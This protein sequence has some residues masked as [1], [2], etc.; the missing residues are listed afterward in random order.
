MSFPPP[1]RSEISRNERNFKFLSFLRPRGHCDRQEQNQYGLGTLSLCYDYAV[2]SFLAFLS[3][4][5]E[6][7]YAYL[8]YNFRR[9]ECLHRHGGRAVGGMNYL[10]WLESWDRGFESHSRHKCL[11]AFILCLCCPVYRQRPCDWLITRP[12]SPTVCMKKDYETEE[13]ARAQQRAVE[14][15]MNEWMKSEC[16]HIT[17]QPIEGFS[18]KLCISTIN[19]KYKCEGRGGG[20]RVFPTFV[21]LKF[22]PSVTAHGVRRILVFLTWQQHWRRLM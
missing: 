14:P 1:W 21:L 8:S 17:C 7:I 18:K 19:I 16:L 3:L 4:F 10:R 6:K 5:Y 22:L 9:S 13:E 20:L 11:C 15:L 2:M 12:R